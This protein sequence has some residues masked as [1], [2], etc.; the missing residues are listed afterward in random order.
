ML[1]PA[2]NSPAKSLSFWMRAM[3]DWSGDYGAHF[4]I[5]GWLQD[6]FWNAL[7]CLRGIQNELPKIRICLYQRIFLTSTT[8]FGSGWS[9]SLSS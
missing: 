1:A 7:R 6:G 8:T 9:T 5:P 3:V 4:W 2:T